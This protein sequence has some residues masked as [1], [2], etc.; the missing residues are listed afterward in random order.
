M[1]K[2]NTVGY[3][4]QLACGKAQR[5]IKQLQ[6][7]INQPTATERYRQ[8]A[9]TQIKELESGIRGTRMYENGKRIK[10]KS[11]QTVAHNIERITQ[12]L[13][14]SEGARY[15]KGDTMKVTQK[16][17]RKASVGV[18]SI[19][20][21]TE[22]DVFYRATMEAWRNKPVENRDQIIIDYYNN[23]LRAQGKTPMSFTELVETILK[24]YHEHVT[25]L[26][27]IDEYEAMSEEELEL[28]AQ[29]ER[30]MQAYRELHGEDK[31]QDKYNTAAILELVNE[32]RSIFN[33]SGI[34]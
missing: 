17:L 12:S 16:E 25:I 2:R 19:Y 27:N 11:M 29:Y 8:W 1:A 7:A 30:E 26:E 18:E 9:E 14:K 31:K 20:T 4:A 22:N 10:S 6:K 33:T 24:K 13:Q 32:L 34:I 23:K 21:K 28:Y 3:Q 5:R 15:Y